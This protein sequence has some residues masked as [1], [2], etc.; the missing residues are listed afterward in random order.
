M[1]DTE[2]ANSSPKRLPVE[3]SC[4]KERWHERSL[5]QLLLM[6]CFPTKIILGV[7][8]IGRLIPSK[9]VCLAVWLMSLFSRSSHGTS[10]RW[11]LWQL[12]KLS[13]T[14]CWVSGKENFS[15]NCEVKK[16]SPNVFLNQIRNQNPGRLLFSYF[17][18]GV[19]LRPC[20]E[21]IIHIENLSILLKSLIFILGK[22]D[23]KN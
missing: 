5:L 1:K 18:D 17:A 8:L 6:D 22:C 14:L 2:V 19:L 4:M 23:S 7:V 15:I 11:R 3:W 16:K 12:E 10:I 20:K 9:V 13:W 21:W